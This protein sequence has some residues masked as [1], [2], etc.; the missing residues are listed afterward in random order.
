MN[1]EDIENLIDQ[2]I[3][4]AEKKYG[5]EVKFL[6]IE[7][8]SL[9]KMLRPEKKEPTRLI[10]VSQW[11]KYYSYPSVAGLRMKIFN[12][13]TNGFT[14]YGVVRRDGRRV[15]IDEQAYF[16]W[17]ARGQEEAS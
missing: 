16:R 12:E 5:K 17:Q 10:P 11:G 14:K 9:E 8:L 1:K 3:S 2:K 15:L 4:F 6:L 13:E 7:T